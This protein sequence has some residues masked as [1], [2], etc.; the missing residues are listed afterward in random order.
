MEGWMEGGR[1]GGRD[2]YV[3]LSKICGLTVPENFAEEPF[4]ALQNLKSGI[5]KCWG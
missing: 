4:C 3:L 2:Y 5:E 1:E